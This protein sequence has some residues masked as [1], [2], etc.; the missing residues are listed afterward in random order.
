MWDAREPTLLQ[1]AI[2]ATLGHAQAMSGADPEA[3]AEIVGFETSLYTAHRFDDV[4]GDLTD[5]AHGGAA[6]LVTQPFEVADNDPDAAGFQRDAFTLF[7]A[8]LTADPSTARGARRAS[9]ARGEQLFNTHTFRIRGVAGLRDRQGTC[10]T[11]HNARNLGSNSAAGTMDIRVSDDDDRP[12]QLPV[13][14]LRNRATGERIQTTDPGQAIVT[15]RW[16]DLGRFKVPALR[17]L[18]MRAP[19]FHNGLA[20]D[21]DDVVDFYRQRFGIGLSG[22][23]QRDLVAFLSVL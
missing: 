7:G 19:Y 1:Q 23:E 4:A 15:G 3:M 10:S 20:S 14:T 21:L 16:A 5:G 12:S 2:D 18:A 22:R 6:A 8:W 17:G 13:Y 9:I 11:C